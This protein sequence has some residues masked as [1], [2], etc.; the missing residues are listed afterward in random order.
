MKSSKFYG[1][2]CFV[3]GVVAAAFV[4]F[5]LLW[6]ISGCHAVGFAAEEPAPVDH[7]DTS[8]LETWCG[9]PAGTIRMVG[10][11]FDGVDTFTDETGEMWGWDGVLD[12]NGFYLLW[13]DDNGTPDLT[14][15]FIVK[16]FQEK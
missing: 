3:G 14:D 10:A 16:V 6:A 9:E 11:E 2:A 1:N 8:V 13:I 7:F 5:F 12:E 4:W 15:D